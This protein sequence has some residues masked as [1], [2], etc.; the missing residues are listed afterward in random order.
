MS[1]FSYQGGEEY[2]VKPFIDHIHSNR[3][4]LLFYHKTIIFFHEGHK[5]IHMN[6]LFNYQIL[7]IIPINKSKNQN[8]L[9]RY[10]SEIDFIM[11]L[12]AHLIDLILDCLL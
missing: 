5:S 11:Q 9:Y 1:C 10:D 12:L 6:I 8:N 3:V 4:V 2:D 7:L